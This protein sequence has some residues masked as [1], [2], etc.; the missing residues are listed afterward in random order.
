[1]TTRQTNSDIVL[2]NTIQI[3]DTNRSHLST[4]T[5]GYY[6]N[7]TV[8]DEEEPGVWYI[9][10][11][12]N[13]REILQ[14]DVYQEYQWSLLEGKPTYWDQALSTYVIWRASEYTGDWL[15]EV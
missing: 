4:T 6:I 11:R 13:L 9:T 2:G 7:V 14:Q 12:H 10:D 5:T 3:I 8:S 15:P 1:M